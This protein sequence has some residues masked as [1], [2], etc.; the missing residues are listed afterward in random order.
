MSEHGIRKVGRPVPDGRSTEKLIA[1]VIEYK[2]KYDKKN[3]TFSGLEK[4]YGIKRHIWRDRKEVKAKIEQLNEVD[5]GIDNINLLRYN[6]ELLPNV[7]I[8]I[9]RYGNNYKKI[10]QVLQE[11]DEFVKGLFERSCEYAQYKLKYDEALV[12]NADLENEVKSL[13]IEC[14]Y[15]KNEY[16]KICADSTSLLNRA[17]KG[18]KENVIQI[19]RQEINS[20]FDDLY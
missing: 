18:I 10:V 4:E 14:E 3:I 1:Y 8:I 2:K 11:Y 19:N 17:Q 15:Y 12:R 7:E 20:D 13:Q 6:I 5:L 16:F 9:S